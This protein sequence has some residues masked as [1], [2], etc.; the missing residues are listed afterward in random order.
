MPEVVGCPKC[1]FICTRPGIDCACRHAKHAD[2]CPFKI[3]AT[4]TIAIECDHGYDVCPKCDPC[5]C[6]VGV[7]I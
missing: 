7:T 5:T 1:N 2:D 3:A 6:G 4:M